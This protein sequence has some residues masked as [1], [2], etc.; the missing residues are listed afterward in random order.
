MLRNIR[1][2]RKVPINMPWYWQKYFSIYLCT[3]RTIHINLRP[4][5][6]ELGG[7]ENIIGKQKKKVA[8]N[9]PRSVIKRKNIIE[10]G[11]AS[12]LRVKRE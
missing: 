4:R 5:L 3:K 1:G 12:C 6:K 11:K 10:K 2:I 7:D 8:I 9:S